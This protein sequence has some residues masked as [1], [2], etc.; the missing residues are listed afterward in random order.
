MPIRLFRL[1]FALVLFVA[2]LGIVLVTPALRVRILTDMGRY[3][4]H[5]DPLATADAIVIAVDGSGPEVLEAADLVREGQAGKV[6]VL[7][8]PPDLLG[9]EFARHG[10]PD[11]DKATVAV[12][13]LHALGVK[14]AQMATPRVDGS[15]SE[16]AML[17]RWC[18]SH[19][20]GKVIFIVVADHSYRVRRMLDR[21]LVD[22]GID[23]DIR[24]HVSRYA[25]FK[26]DG[27]WSG[28]GGV[29]TLIVEYQKLM[30]DLLSHPLSDQPRPPSRRPDSGLSGAPVSP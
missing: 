29:R 18:V 3:L 4:I 9:Q 7:A 27:W 24:I 15:N 25:P 16:T 13:T 21:A 10:L 11:S 20:Y 5:N 14:D 22:S 6:W 23:A 2:A 8:G 30:L 26:A 28:R 19:Q 1:R 12:Q 17:P